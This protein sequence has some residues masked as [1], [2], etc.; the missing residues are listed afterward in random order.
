MNVDNS[1]RVGNITQRDGDINIGNKI[2]NSVSFDDF[3]VMLREFLEE[4][5]NLDKTPFS[6]K[7]TEDIKARITEIRNDLDTV[8][9]GY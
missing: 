5:K 1:I 4:L 2:Q 6:D 7:E 9:G 8:F 3:K